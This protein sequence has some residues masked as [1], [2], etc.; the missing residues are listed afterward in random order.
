MI[1]EIKSVA[2]RY[3]RSHLQ[4]LII[5]ELDVIKAEKL[6]STYKKFL[7]SVELDDCVIE[8]YNFWSLLKHIV[9][10]DV[11]NYLDKRT[12]RDLYYIGVDLKEHGLSLERLQKIEKLGFH[13]IGFEHEIQYATDLKQSPNKNIIEG[14]TILKPSMK[15][16]NS[17]KPDPEKVSF[18]TK[19]RGRPRKHE[20]I[21]PSIGEIQEIKDGGTNVE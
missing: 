18:G 13:T 21:S 17:K 10:T 16:E 20:I 1:K 11:L 14:V 3:K 15:V 6:Y 12:Y 2:N 8:K 9:P 4:C 19:K 5:Q 7:E